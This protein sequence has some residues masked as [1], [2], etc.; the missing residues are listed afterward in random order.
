MCKLQAIAAAKSAFMGTGL[1]VVGVKAVRDLEMCSSC[2]DIT[3]FVLLS[4]LENVKFYSLFFV[5]LCRG[6]LVGDV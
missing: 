3:E 5:A 4:Q 2:D 6:D 1:F